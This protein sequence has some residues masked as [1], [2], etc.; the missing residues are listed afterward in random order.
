[1][2]DSKSAILEGFDPESDLPSDLDQIKI[3]LLRKRRQELGHSGMY[4]DESDE[5]VNPETLDELT[6]EEQEY[7]L[8]LLDRE[9]IQEE[10]AE[11]VLTLMR[12]HSADIMGFLPGLI[13][14]F[15][16]LGKRLYYFCSEVDDKKEVVAALREYVDDTETQITEYQLFWFAKMAED[17]LLKSPNVGELL[18][19]LYEHPEATDISKAK[20]LEIPDK[21][22]GLADLRE[23]RL[24]TGHSDWLTWSAAVGSRVHAKAQRNQMLKYVRNLLQ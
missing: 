12:D 18:L 7:L 2:S 22:F 14:D 19:S 3:Q 15:P 6:D 9:T 5:Y 17:Y 24:K 23:E 11:L 20:I 1:M 10:D 21:R 4:A 16:S 8:A 13:R